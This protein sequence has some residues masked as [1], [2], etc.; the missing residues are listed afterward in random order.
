MQLLTLGRD[1]AITTSFLT[2]LSTACPGA[3]SAYTAHSPSEF[4]ALAQQHKDS[5][6]LV[7]L[8]AAQTDGQATAA[9]QVVDEVWGQGGMRI[10]RLPGALL[11][12]EGKKGGMLRWFL[13]QVEKH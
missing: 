10:L 11:T 7:L 13:E 4:R 9:R 5:I 12:E 8:G 2:Q 1:P 3:Y 6:E